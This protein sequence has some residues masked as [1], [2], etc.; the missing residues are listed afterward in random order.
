MRFFRLKSV[1]RA[2]GS[3]GLLG[4]CIV[5]VMVSQKKLDDWGNAFIHEV[6]KEPISDREW[7]FTFQRKT[8]KETWCIFHT[9]RERVSVPKGSVRCHHGCPLSVAQNILQDRFIIGP[10]GALWF[11]THG[12]F[13]YGRCHALDRCQESYGW[14]ENGQVCLW[15]LPVTISF[16]LSYSCIETNG[17]A[18]VGINTIT[19]SDVMRLPRIPGDTKNILYNQEVSLFS[20]P[21]QYG[22]IEIHVCLRHYWNY[23]AWDPY[24]VETRLAVNVLNENIIEELQKGRVILC[25]CKSKEPFLFS[26]VS[27]GAITS[28]ANASDNGWYC[29]KTNN[30]WYCPECRPHRIEGSYQ[31]LNPDA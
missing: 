24:F 4:F 10:S 5:A 3:E 13:G 25:C 22:S 19:L 17:H 20:P 29:S 30:Y 27:C 26:H 18:P 1:H 15:T 23:Q 12:L 16:V 8:G 2:E 28:E 21:F 7:F 31:V 9:Q 11:C 14:K 6:L